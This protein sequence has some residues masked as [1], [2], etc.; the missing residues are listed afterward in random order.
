MSM[1]R[2]PIVEE[3]RKVRE[4]NSARFNHDV[5]RIAEDARQ[6]QKESGRKVIPAPPPRTAR[7]RKRA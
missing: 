7:K 3:V 1:N 5:D 6:R 2:D 4:A